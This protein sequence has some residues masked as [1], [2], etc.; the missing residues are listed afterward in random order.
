MIATL[1]APPH[2]AAFR[3]D[4]SLTAEDLHVCGAE[5]ERRLATQPRINLFCDLTRHD[6]ATP[7]H[8]TADIRAA[9]GRF[10]ELD[11]CAIVT[12]QPW[13]EAIGAARDA[14]FPRAEL[15][16]FDASEREAA[17]AWASERPLRQR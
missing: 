6:G 5:V 16:C 9:F 2:L 12:Q 1:P 3:F 8:V 17:M 15:R 7:E 10:D 13:A 11:R 14:M 4:G